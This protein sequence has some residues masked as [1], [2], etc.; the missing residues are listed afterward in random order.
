MARGIYNCR[1]DTH[2]AN[3]GM[4]RLLAKSGYTYCG[5]IVALDGIDRLAYQKFY[6]VEA[7]AL[8]RFLLG[9]ARLLS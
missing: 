3:T 9:L 5:I 2:A 6:P 4:R 7:P 8:N 1:I